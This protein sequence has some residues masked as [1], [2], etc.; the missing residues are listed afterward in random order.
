MDEGESSGDGRYRNRNRK[1]AGFI[2]LQYLSRTSGHV[3]VSGARETGGG[4][5]RI[6]LL[7]AGIHGGAEAE[8]GGGAFKA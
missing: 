7:R 3:R 5:R 2:L 8:A 6:I 4:G 1:R